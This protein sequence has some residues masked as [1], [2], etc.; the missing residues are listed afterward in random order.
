MTENSAGYVP[1]FD[2]GNPRTIGGYAREV[3]SGGQFVFASGVTNTV[4]SGANSFAT[5]DILFS[6]AASGAKFNGICATTK[7]ASGAT[8]AVA[9]RGMF[10]V[11]ANGTVTNGQ[12]VWTDGYHAV[13]N[14]GSLAGN[15]ACL[16]PMARALTDAT[17]GG[18]CII[19]LLG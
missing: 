8:I 10:I 5:T 14:A 9:T 12:K 17:S 11:V 3:I 4:S 6:V 16:S 19:D 7:A 2:G 13:A 18:H 15:V 1:V